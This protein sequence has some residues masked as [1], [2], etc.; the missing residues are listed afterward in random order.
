VAF[1]HFLD[2]LLIYSG[3]PSRALAVASLWVKDIRFYRQAP[4]ESATWIAIIS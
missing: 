1:G 2:V 3:A 4:D